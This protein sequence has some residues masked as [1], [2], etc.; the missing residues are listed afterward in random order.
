MYWELDAPLWITGRYRPVSH[1]V[2]EDQYFAML[3]GGLL[4][5]Y[6]LFQKEVS[7]LDSTYLSENNCLFIWIIYRSTKQEVHGEIKPNIG[8][9]WN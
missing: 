8:I 2:Y 5:I 1:I 4:E 6:N 7:Y 3:S 9:L